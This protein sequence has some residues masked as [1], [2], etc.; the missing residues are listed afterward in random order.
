MNLVWKRG[1]DLDLGP[2][3]KLK[4]FECKCGRCSEQTLSRELLSRL[5]Q[6][7]EKFGKP[8]TVTSAF[9]CSAYQARLRGTLPVGHTALGT[10]THEEGRAVDVTATDLDGLTKL[11][12]AHFDSIG[13]ANTFTHVDMRP[14]KPTGKRTWKYV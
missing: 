1:A 6:V 12:E 9:R 7:R 5:Q 8:I 4:E 3:F 2:H 10:S 13:Y 14:A 11:L